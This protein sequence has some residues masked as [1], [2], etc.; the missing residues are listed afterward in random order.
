MVLTS[1]KLASIKGVRGAAWGGL[2]VNPGS[3]WSELGK[4]FVADVVVDLVAVF[5]VQTNPKWHNFEDEMPERKKRCKN[6]VGPVP[7][8]HWTLS[9]PVPIPPQNWFCLGQRGYL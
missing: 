5:R 7:D 1:I 9:V 6:H 2:G 4:L 3:S 8:Q